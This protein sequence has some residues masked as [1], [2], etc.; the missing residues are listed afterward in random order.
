GLVH[1]VLGRGQDG[2]GEAVRL[3]GQ[4]QIGFGAL[5]IVGPYIRQ[6]RVV[7]FGARRDRHAAQRRATAEE[8]S[9]D[10]VLALDGV[11][12]RLTDAR[13][14]E[15]SG[16]AVESRFMNGPTVPSRRRVG[17]CSTSVMDCQGTYS[18]MSTSPACSAARRA[19]SSA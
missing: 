3:A 14:G 12:H 13:I 10:D 1:A 16:L 9:L 4:R 6:G 7:E 17:S 2:A 5:G 19:F 15:R 8:C 18:M 11:S